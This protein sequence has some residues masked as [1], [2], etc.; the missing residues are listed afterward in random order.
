[1]FKCIR[2]DDVAIPSGHH[3]VFDKYL[4]FMFRHGS[5]NS[6]R[7][8]AFQASRKIYVHVLVFLS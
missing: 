7:L 6:N 1:M 3:S 5:G 4:D 2:L 8:N